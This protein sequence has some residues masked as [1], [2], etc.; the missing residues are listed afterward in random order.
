MKLLRVNILLLICLCI[1][2][3]SLSTPDTA[4]PLLKPD[5][6]EAFVD[7]EFSAEGS[8]N[9]VISVISNR[10][11]FAHL[12]D[13]ENP[14]DPSDETQSVSWGSIDVEGHSNLSSKVDTVKVTVS[15]NRNLSTS[16][17]KGTLDIYSEGKKAASVLL[18]QKG[19]VYHLE[20]LPEKTLAESYTDIIPVIVNCNT[21]WTAELVSSTAEVTLS[22]T[23]GFDPETINVT[24]AENAD[25][26]QIKEAIICFKAVGCEDK[27]IVLTQKQATPYLKIGEDFNAKLLSGTNEGKLTFMTNCDWTAE[28]VDGALNNIKLGANHGT[29]LIGQEQTINFTFNNSSQDPSIPAK[30]QIIIRTEHTEPLVVEIQQRPQMIIRFSTSMGFTPELSYTRNTTETVHS[31]KYADKDYALKL[32]LCY[33]Y[34]ANTTGVYFIGNDAD[35]PGYIEFPAIEGATLKA[36]HII[37]KSNGTYYRIKAAITSPDGTQLSNEFSFATASKVCEHTFVLGENGTYPEVGKAYRLT[38]LAKLSCLLNQI[39]LSYE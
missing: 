20:V 28:A 10:S 39:I 29:A 35:G 23:S 24:F 16:A 9:V 19:A 21:N 5:I 2:C 4:E 36:V 12:N 30:G 33:Y 7:A 25:V 37:T 18:T 32:R 15:F 27:T 1:S 22:K 6:L 31:F 26:Q 14:I 3:T 17:I 11:W 13:L 8:E 38:G 34:K